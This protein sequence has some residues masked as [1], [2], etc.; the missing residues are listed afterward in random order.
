[1]PAVTGPLKVT[2]AAVRRAHVRERAVPQGAHTL[3]TP[4]GGHTLPG[5][6]GRDI[7]PHPPHAAHA[8]N[9]RRE[10]E[11]VSHRP[12][13]LNLPVAPGF[14]EIPEKERRAT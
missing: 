14:E 6:A 7:A 1:M 11:S 8:T 13:A 12:V 9:T 10:R 2:P 3:R 4:E 5:S